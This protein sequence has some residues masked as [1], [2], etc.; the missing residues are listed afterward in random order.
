M[1]ERY[2]EELRRRTRVVRIFPNATS[3]LRLILALAA[4]TRERWLTE[5]RYLYGRVSTPTGH[6]RKFLTQL[7]KKNRQKISQPEA[8]WSNP[9]FIE[10]PTY[11]SEVVPQNE[12]VFSDDLRCVGPV[13]QE[14]TGMLEASHHRDP[15]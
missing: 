4:E 10:M 8:A 7:R 13:S 3:C 1:L 2:N 15:L 5:Q 14:V 12:T 6:C 9:D 11:R